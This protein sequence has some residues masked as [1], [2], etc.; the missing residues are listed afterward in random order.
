MMILKVISIYNSH[1]SWF[2]A[3]LTCLREA[4][5][6]CSRNSL[7]SLVLSIQLI[8]IVCSRVFHASSH[9]G[10]NF[11]LPRWWFLKSFWFTIAITHGLKPLLLARERRPIV[12]QGPFYVVLFLSIQLISIVCCRVFHSLS[13]GGFNFAP[14]LWR[15]HMSYW[16]SIAITHGIKLLLLARERRPVVAQGPFYIV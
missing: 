4:S 13:H 1:N 15:F 5:D 7:H 8:S 2:K 12:A 16:Y 11:S 6:R 14:P 9:G 3:V 10:F